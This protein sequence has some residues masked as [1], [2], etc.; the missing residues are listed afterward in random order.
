MNQWLL[1]LAVGFASLVSTPPALGQA[2]APR[3]IRATESESAVAGVEE[4]WCY[5]GEG[6]EAL[7]PTLCHYSPAPPERAPKTLVI[8]L[9]G[10][11]L[12]GTTWQWSGHRGLARAAKANGFE[13]IMPRGRLG[14]GSQKFADHWN[15]P[16]SVEGQ[17]EHEDEVVGEWLEAKKIL[18]ER[19]GR[20]F[21]RLYVFGFSAGAYYAASLAL[22]GRL[23]VSGYAVFA[24][25]GAPGGVARWAKGNSK[26]PIY[27]GYGFKDRA[28]RDPHKLARALKAMGWKHRAVARKNVGHSMTDAQ[29]REA[30]AFLDGRAAPVD[31]SAAGSS[32]KQKKQP[33]SRKHGAKRLTKA[34]RSE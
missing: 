31:K 10:V 34:P 26:M 8:F 29:I 23:P 1:P 27:V 3:P 24:G 25:G 30:L 14:A 5:P 17:R 16:T 13:V 18:E 12:Q 15:W 9:H 32:K 28:W 11:T 6:I 4:P 20:P 7:T 33:R 21:E 2:V 22:R 19:N